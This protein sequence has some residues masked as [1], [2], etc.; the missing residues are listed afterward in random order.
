MAA[1]LNQ[2]NA[3][4][5]QINTIWLDIERGEW[6]T[7]QASNQQVIRDLVSQAQ[8]VADGDFLNFR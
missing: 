1:T 4:G 2:L 5:A 3:T 7:N 8:V 6:P